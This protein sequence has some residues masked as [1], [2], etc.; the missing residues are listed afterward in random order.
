MSKDLNAEFAL[1]DLEDLHFFL[2]V[3]VKKHED[4][5]H[6]SH[7][8]YATDLVKRVG[9]QGYKTI[10]NSIIQYRK[11]ISSRRTTLQPRG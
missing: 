11:I 1:T 2:G 4:D 8:K 10:I 6:L 5:L 9:L 3:V 7:E